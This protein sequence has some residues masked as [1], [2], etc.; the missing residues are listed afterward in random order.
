MYVRGAKIVPTLSVIVH[1]ELPQL[2]LEVPLSVPYIL[3][4]CVTGHVCQGSSQGAP[5]GS[6]NGDIERPG[7]RPQRRP[8][9][10]AVDVPTAHKYQTVI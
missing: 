3:F 1:L 5:R 4:Q 7:T 9:G 2:N 10:R 6:H 8:Y